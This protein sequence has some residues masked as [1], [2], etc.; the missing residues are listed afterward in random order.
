MFYVILGVFSI[1]M[2]IYRSVTY[3]YTPE[4]YSTSARTSAVGI[5]SAADRFAS[6][7]QPIIF[8]SLVYSSF[9]LAFAC[10]GG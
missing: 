7:L 1:F 3:A 8:S 2:K 5:M 6:I 9:K 4:V 10:F